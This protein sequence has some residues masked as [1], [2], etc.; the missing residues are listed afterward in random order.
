MRWPDLRP[1]RGQ[2]GTWT[3]SEIPQRLVFPLVIGNAWEFTYTGRSKKRKVK[4]RSRVRVV[5]SEEVTVSAGV[6]RGWK[7]VITSMW[8]ATGDITSSGTMAETLWY[9][10]EIK[11]FVKRILVVA[12]RKGGTTRSAGSRKTVYELAAYNIA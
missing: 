1:N 5:G 4:V 6:F 2:F 12:W 9:S 11:R 3:Y 10:P 8:R 7:V